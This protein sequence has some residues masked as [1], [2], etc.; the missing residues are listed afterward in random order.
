MHFGDGS[1]CRR[2]DVSGNLKGMRGKNMTGLELS[3]FLKICTYFAL[4]KFWIGENTAG[5]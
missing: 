3:T 4:I 2:Y 1:L 5:E